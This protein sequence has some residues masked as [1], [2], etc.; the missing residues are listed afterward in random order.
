[1][2]IFLV[3]SVYSKQ[4][5][6]LFTNNTVAYKCLWVIITIYVIYTGQFSVE[7]HAISDIYQTYTTVLTNYSDI[8]LIGILV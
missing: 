3:L 5:F 7:I 6:T 1:M 4:N 8:C 2:L